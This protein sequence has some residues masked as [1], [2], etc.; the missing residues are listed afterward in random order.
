MEQA[1]SSKQPPS[2]TSYQDRKSIIPWIERNG[3]AHW[4]M[5]ISWVVIALVAFN[6]VGAV[7][8]I[9]AVIATTGATDLQTVME[10]MQTNYDAIFLANTTGQVFIFALA[11]LLLVKLHAVKGKRRKFL[12]LQT[13]SNVWAVTAIAVLL[14]VAAQPFILFL[15]W[16]NSFLP[17]PEIFSQLQE[18]M[19]E[20][21]T[22]Y[23]KS[24]NAL[25][26]GVFYIGIVPAVCEEIM[27]RGYVMRC[28]EKRWSITTAIIV[29]GI[30][31]GMYHIQ[32]S[33]V[34]PLSVLGML[35]A[36]VTYVSDS[37][38]PAM[39]AHLVNNGGQVIASSFYPEMLDQTMTPETELPWGLVILSVI[40]TAG[41]LYFLN[42]LREK[43]GEA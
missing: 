5:A 21:I 43:E 34:L 41:L 27:Y 36:Y 39:A 24:D 9:I 2:E 37:L 15:G 28:F 20:T 29:S 17:V 1:S 22:N 42:T 4:A 14:F 40:I 23:L 3:F 13:S 35:L 18:S 7:V 16:L 31:F 25:L 30:I 10:Q 32:P 19:M 26:M 38:I 11:T 6:V 33:N 12:R 8:G